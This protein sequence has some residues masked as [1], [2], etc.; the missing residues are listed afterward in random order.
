MKLKRCM[1]SRERMKN[2]FAFKMPDRIG[3]FDAPWPETV[4]RWHKEGLPED[5]HVNEYFNYDVD[6]CII[7]DT[8]FR[9]PKRI[10]GSNK[11][12]IVYTDWNGVTNKVIRN[13][14]GAP[15]TL[16][17]LIK[18]RK[19]WLEYKHLLSVSRE[20]IQFIHW[21][22]YETV[23]EENVET[24]ASSFSWQDTVE[25][26]R[27][28]LDRDKF[29]FFCA[30]GPFE[31]ATHMLNPPE[32]YLKLIEEPEFIVDIFDT[33]TALIIES[34]KDMKK[35]GIE[36]DG[37]HFLDDIAYKN[38]MLFFPKTYKELLFPYHKKLCSF[39]KSKG[40]PVSYHTD[41][42]LDEALP[43][44]VET[45]ITAI[46]PLEAKVGNDVRRLKNTYGRNL[47][48]IDNIDT[49]KMSGS[50]EEIEEEVKS[51]VLTAKENGGYVFHSD[52]SVPP[53]VSFKNYRYTMELVRSYGQY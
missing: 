13:Q 28:V 35:N 1:T 48:F 17:Y 33:M 5:I 26:Y 16:D 39:F 34:Y 20:R 7:L 53:T 49:R 37:F 12:Y 31:N 38:G 3:V 11:D 30:V 43:L 41:G 19:K 24:Q 22:E 14:T 29:I 18:N 36:A 44:L 23:N 15:I 2:I 52:H 10:L 21:G 6:E 42:K 45:G 4:V 8:S 40:M 47:V 50:E 32:I 9:L 46:Q 25:K 51:K 27:K